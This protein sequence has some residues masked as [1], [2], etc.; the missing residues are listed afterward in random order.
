VQ[1]QVECKLSIFHP[2]VYPYYRPPDAE[3]EQQEDFE[4]SQQ[5]STMRYSVEPAATL[6]APPDVGK[7][8]APSMLGAVKNFLGYGSPVLEERKQGDNRKTLKTVSFE[9]PPEDMLK[10]RLKATPGEPDQMEEEELQRR[11]EYE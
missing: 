3:Q 1:L 10:N 9:L 6:Q 5:R 2:F 11:M 8:Q 7:P 4:A